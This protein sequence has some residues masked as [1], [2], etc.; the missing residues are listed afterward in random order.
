M[1]KPVRDGEPVGDAVAAQES[2]GRVAIL[3]DYHEGIYLGLIEDGLFDLDT[4]DCRR[5][6]RPGGRLQDLN[7][8]VNLLIDDNDYSEV[9]RPDLDHQHLVR[10]HG[11]GGLVHAQG[12]ERQRRRLLVP[13]TARILSPTTR[14]RCWITTNPGAR[15]HVPQ[16]HARPARNV[17]EN[18]SW[19]GYMQPLTGVTPQV[20]VKEQILPRVPDIHRRATLDLP[21]GLFELQLPV[22]ADALWQQAWLVVSNGI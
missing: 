22:D 12:R 15:A 10:G 19:N 1:H 6:A 20:L 14:T 17:L 16:L 13:R 7:G 8:L 11:R 18:I 4:T 3:D 21:S 9:H 2:K 5:I